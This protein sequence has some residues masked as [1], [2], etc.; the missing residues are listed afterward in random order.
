M[1]RGFPVGGVPNFTGFNCTSC[2][3]KKKYIYI[4]KKNN[5]NKNKNVH[6]KIK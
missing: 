3:V 4:T 2:F 1:A 6:T 5:N